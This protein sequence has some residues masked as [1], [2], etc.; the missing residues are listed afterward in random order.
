MYQLPQSGISSNQSMSRSGIQIPQTTEI[1]GQGSESSQIGSR[2]GGENM[3][4]SRQ[5]TARS[6]TPATQSLYYE[7]Q[8]GQQ[9]QGRTYVSTAGNLYGSQAQQ[10]STT[11][12]SSLINTPIEGLKYRSPSPKGAKLT[13]SI[14]K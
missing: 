8:L 6:I 4:G 14:L 12:Q 1:I 13:E 2:Q 11:Q 7:Q 9:Q 3:Y 10:S 5:G